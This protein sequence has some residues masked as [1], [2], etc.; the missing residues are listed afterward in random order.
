MS[1]LDFMSKKKLQIHYVRISDKGRVT[2]PAVLRQR[3][4]LRPGDQVV[5]RLDNGRLVLTRLPS[6]PSKH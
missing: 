2:I 5:W 1:I 4:K 3:H 6:A